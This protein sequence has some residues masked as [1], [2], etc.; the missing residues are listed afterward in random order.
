VKTTTTSSTDQTGFSPALTLTAG[1]NYDVSVTPAFPGVT[2]PQGCTPTGMSSF[3]APGSIVTTPPPGSS[4]GFSI[5]ALLLVLSIVLLLLGG[6]VFVIGWC[7]AVIWVWIVGAAI[8]VVGLVLFLIW[9]FLCAKQTP[10]TLMWTMECILDWIVRTAWIIAVIA[11][12]FGGS[13]P[14]ALA[15]VSAWGGWALL[16]NVLR[17]VMFRAGCP[18]IDC[19]MP[20]P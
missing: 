14:C 7:I 4:S 1:D 19:T 17:T 18:P 11:L 20:R 5:C 9:A 6:I 15:A 3:Q 16:D 13:L 10:C 8:G 12:I 2:L